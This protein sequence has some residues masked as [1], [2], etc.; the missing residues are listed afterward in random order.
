LARSNDS[1]LREKLSLAYDFV[2][3]GSSG[4]GNG[5]RVVLDRCDSSSEVLLCRVFRQPRG[6][7]GLANVLSDDLLSGRST[8]RLTGGVSTSERVYGSHVVLLELAARAVV[9]D[10][11]ELPMLLPILGR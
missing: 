10:C 2:W 5:G 11:S 4:Y 1:S 3:G 8:E 9:C 7:G 6:L